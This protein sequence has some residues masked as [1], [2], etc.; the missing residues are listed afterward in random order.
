MG[1]LEENK[2]KCHP[3]HLIVFQ[4]VVIR[5]QYL[6][7]REK[8]TESPCFIFPPFEPPQLQRRERGAPGTRAREWKDQPCRFNSVLPHLVNYLPTP[9]AAKPITP[10]LHRDVTRLLGCVMIAVTVSFRFPF[11]I[12]KTAARHRQ[13]F[14]Q[15]T[16]FIFIRFGPIAL[17]PQEPWNLFIGLFHGGKAL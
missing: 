15:E 6:V 5:H 7:L 17:S 1:K 2:M 4:S 16:G 12:D 13:Q 10:Y 8:C 14:A 11:V 3:R 9:T